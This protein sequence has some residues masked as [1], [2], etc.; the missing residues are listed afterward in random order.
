MPPLKYNTFDCTFEFSL[1]DAAA[2]TPR[3]GRA[4]VT[5]WGESP[6]KIQAEILRQHPEYRNVTLLSADPYGR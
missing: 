6:L 3:V 2:E 1:S 5:V 4:I